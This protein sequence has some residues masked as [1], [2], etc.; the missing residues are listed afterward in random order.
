VIFLSGSLDGLANSDR[1]ESPC[2]FLVKPVNLTDVTNTVKDLMSGQ[3]NP[4]EI[5][6]NRASSGHRQIEERPTGTPTSDR[7]AMEIMH[8][9]ED[10]ETPAR[11]PIGSV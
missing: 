5:V 9:W 10:E 2:A 7:H 11:K 4:A 8:S 3:R 6:N 1:V